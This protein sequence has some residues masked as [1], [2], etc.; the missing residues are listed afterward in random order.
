[1]TAPLRIGVLRPDR[2]FA[3][4][5][6]AEARVVE[7]ELARRLGP[8]V[9]DLRV[10]GAALGRWQPAS[11]AG[12]PANL[13][14]VAPSEALW[15]AGSSPLTALFAT[16]V[17][18]RAAEVRARMLAHLELAVS[19][20]DDDAVATLSRFNP[21][22][23]DCW[24]IATGAAVVTATDP[25]WS[26]L[27][28]PTP[29]QLAQLAAAFDAAAASLAESPAIGAAQAVELARRSAECAALSDEVARL[30]AELTRQQAEAADKIDDLT[31]SL[32]AA[33]DRL[34]RAA[35]QR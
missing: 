6:D 16:T 9:L 14:A 18:P 15:A 2:P 24:L 29:Q 22:P 7:H 12:W 4:L 30:R 20:L 21:S 11:H 27:A 13:D 35:L 1:V 10:D 31:A 8:V 23:T 32:R 25:R 34:A 28:A 26:A 3:P 19:V 5:A 17:E 33:E